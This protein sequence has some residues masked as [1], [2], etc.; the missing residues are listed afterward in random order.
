MEKTGIEIVLLS[1]ADIRSVKK[2][3]CQM[4]NPDIKL[5]KNETF[6]NLPI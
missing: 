1:F 3:T 5:E 6:K 2:K 4:H